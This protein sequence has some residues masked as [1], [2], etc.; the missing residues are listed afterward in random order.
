MF[1]SSNPTNSNTT[2]QSLSLAFLGALIFA[3]VVARI[4]GSI[5]FPIYDDAFITYRYARNLAL[6]QGF[7]YHP[8]EWVLG[9]TCPAFGVLV[10]LFYRLGLNV[11][12]FI[13]AMNIL[14][15]AAILA[16]IVK[17]LASRS[18]SI[19]SG[20][21]VL[22]ALLFAFFFT[23]S[24]TMA[25]ICVGGM[26]VNLFLLASLSAI[27]LYHRGAKIPAIA[28]AAACYFLRPEGALLVCILCG[29]ELLTTRRFSALRLP[30]V[31]LLVLLPFLLIIQHFYG[32]ILPQSVMAKSHVV[33][34]PIFLTAK[35]LVFPDPICLLFLPFTLWGAVNFLREKGWRENSFLRTIGIW[36]LAYLSA[37]MVARPHIWSWYAEP[38]QFVQIL[39][40]ALGAA[41]LLARLPALQKPFSRPGTAALGYPLVT[42]ALAVAFWAL[43][44][45]KQHPS[46]AT[47]YV[48]APLKQWSQS[49]GVKGSTILAEDIGAVGYY[50]NAYIFDAAGLV[51]PPALRYKT[52]DAMIKAYHPDYLFLNAEQDTIEMMQ[53]S[54]LDKVYQPI[55]RFSLD[56]DTE[57]KQDPKLYNTSWKQDYLLYKKRAKPIK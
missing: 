3:L 48:Y 41:N 18:N 11:P 44:L 25:R 16:I 35:A 22:S 43:I 51:W 1:D 54:K 4:I 38:I 13:T 6:G 36:Y 40:A 9:A 7:V 53:H 28:V 32:H 15:D 52:N 26:E 31:A 2:R 27:F 8:G 56:N 12:P 57:L 19:N 17:A 39:F 23:L 5:C 20:V 10:S 42:S 30:L 14:C 49:K 55:R 45:V 37:Y 47:R 21:L 34:R 46:G 50:T 29:L 24:P 33:K